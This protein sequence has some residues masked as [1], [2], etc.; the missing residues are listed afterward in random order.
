MSATVRLLL[1]DDQ[2]LVRSGFRMILGTQPDF[3]VVA[4]AGDGREAVSLGRQLKPDV[5]L[6]DVRMPE[7]DGI[8][9]TR[10]LLA[11][12][13]LRTRV[14]VL[15]TFDGDAN[16]YEAVRAGASGFLLKTVSAGQLI[17][18]VRTV[19]TGDS[20]LDPSVT[21]RLLAAFAR[22]PHP[23]DGV[24]SEFAALSPRELDTARHVARG[25]SNAEIAQRMFLSE[26]TVK[27]HVTAIL[28][29]LG[30]RDRV[31]VV[32]RCYEGGLVR[33]GE[34]SG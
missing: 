23:G 15:T 25:L 29:K 26:P 22:G 32:V 30:V 34:D 16:V 3:D 14:L 18:A 27:T 9:A 7:I 8:E 6:M 5:L 28:A 24:P 12:P 11:D 33:P 1:A 19:A 20:I 4:E 17:E 2:S 13:A 21:G 31:Q 10:I